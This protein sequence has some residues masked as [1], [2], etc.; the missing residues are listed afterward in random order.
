MWNG[1]RDL[2]GE[3][4]R[5]EATKATM[6]AVAMAYICIDTMAF[7]GMPEN[8]EAQSRDDFIDWVNTYLKGHTDQPYQYSG[9]DVYAA[10]CSVLHTFGSEAAFHRNDPNIKLFGYHN[11]GKHA[12]DAAIDKRL[13]IIGT[14]SFLNDVILAVQAFL[15]DCKQDEALRSRVEQRLQKVLQVSPIFR[16]PPDVHNAN[17]SK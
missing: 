9:K 12:Y 15:T 2:I 13:V 17:V 11:G 6:A 8:K 14:A 3:I 4:K 5:C 10:R 1:V 16:A 7:L